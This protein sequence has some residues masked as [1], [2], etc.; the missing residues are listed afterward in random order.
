MRAILRSAVPAI[1]AALLLPAILP[2]QQ[3]A[4][5]GKPAAAVAVIAAD[6]KLKGV[7]EPVSYPVDLYLNDVYFAT[8]EIGWV[9]AGA[10]GQP[11][12]ILH[13]RDGGV[14]WTAQLGDPESSDPAFHDLRFIDAHHGWV[15]QTDK[16]LHT[17]DGEEWS[18]VGSMERNWGLPD[19]EFVS[20]TEGL[21]IDGNDNVSR[22]MRTADGGQTWKEVFKCGASVEIEGLTKNVECALKTLHFPSPRVGYA[23]GGAHGAK[24]TLFVAKT[25]DRGVTWTLWTVPNVGRDTEV[26]H[27]QEAFF[28][29]ELT[30]IAS[31]G[32]DRIYRTTDGGRSWK[33]VVGK[34]GGV[35]RF[36]DP[37]VGWSFASY[38]TLSFTT[39]GG[40]RWTTRE[41]N[42]PGKV[43]GFS[44]PRRDRAFVVGE[45]GM[46]YRY[47]VVGP[48]EST[49]PKALAAVA[50]PA[51]DSP[52][53]ER[54]TELDAVVDALEA[55]VAAASEAAADESEAAAA[56]LEGEETSE[57]AEPDAADTGELGAGDTSES[58]S[59]FTANC[60]G[61]PLGTLDLI[62][63]AVTG[64]VPQFLGQYKNT[65]L[66][67]AG[68][69]MV[70]DLPDR[71]NQL[72]N[73]LRVFRKAPDKAA[74]A[75]ALEQVSAAIAA[76]SQSTAVAFQKHAPPAGEE[77][78]EPEATAVDAGAAED[79][80][81]GQA[82]DAE[83]APAEDGEAIPADEAEAEPAAEESN[84]VDEAGSEASEVVSE[85]VREAEQEK[86][87][88][89]KED[90]K[91][92]IKK[93]LRF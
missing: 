48:G 22:I 26:Y 87:Q 54:V 47:R 61:K 32:D 51:F 55:S 7:W 53:D 86:K 67:V 85:S 84:E 82:Q 78:L 38:Y 69:R 12:M 18:E 42:F 1:A 45:H 57:Y 29:D 65:N 23:L 73:A 25:E 5:K 14:S 41:F 58:I 81:T 89:A 28:T 19:Y 50:M 79:L 2:A 4:K 37:M 43:T 20:P 70:T 93:K 16:L 74:A 40:K 8:P 71:V 33:G 59:P 46:I 75:T 91:K 92:A 72:N 62:L 6:A 13:T 56:P 90:A 88:K 80:E 49:A 11:G 52:L 64:I 3:P 68:V 44:L 35:I 39:D 66:L 30:G 76:L 83:M 15:L 63:T 27:K 24:R 60:C 34:P 10:H 21:Y 31:L 36:S 9:S 77:A 17:S